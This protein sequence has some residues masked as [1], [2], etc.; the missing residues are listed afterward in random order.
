MDAL[1][2]GVTVSLPKDCGEYPE[3]SPQLEALTASVRQALEDG[4][5]V[6]CER[7]NRMTGTPVRKLLTEW[8]EA[9]DCEDLKASWYEA[10]TPWVALWDA[11]YK[12]SILTQEEANALTGG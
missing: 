9:P 10:S 12:I 11:T 6:L 5:A 1:T 2:F 4:Y 3:G 8:D 7:E